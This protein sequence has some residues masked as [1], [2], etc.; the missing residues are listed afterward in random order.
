[1]L[2]AASYAHAPFLISGT[3]DMHERYA[4]DVPIRS[5]VDFYITL[6]ESDCKARDSRRMRD[7][8]GFPVSHLGSGLVSRCPL[9]IPVKATVGTKGK[10]LDDLANMMTAQWLWL[11]EPRNTAPKLSFVL[12]ILIDCEWWYLAALI[13]CDD[14][15]D[16]VVFLLPL[17]RTCGLAY[18][19]KL[20]LSL[21]VLKDWAEQVYRPVVMEHIQAAWG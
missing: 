5:Q 9:A 19:Y 16:K 8:M 6:P 1:M 18:M 10:G 21:R 12:G 15:P 14:G 4:F 2:T 13:P 20:L 7:S 11:R 3:S 17:G